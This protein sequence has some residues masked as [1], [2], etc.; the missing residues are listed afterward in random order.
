METLPKVYTE[1]ISIEHRFTKT[2]IISSTNQRKGN[3]SWCQRERK[4][5]TSKGR[6]NVT[7]FRFDSDWLKGYTSLAGLITKTI[8][9]RLLGLLSTLN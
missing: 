9:F 6:E 3:S 8:A 7:K 4:V 5:K 1:H 2:K